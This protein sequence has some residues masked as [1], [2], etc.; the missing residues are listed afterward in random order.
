MQVLV[1][2]FPLKDFIEDV[3][4]GIDTIFLKF[5]EGGFQAFVPQ[6]GREGHEIG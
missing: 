1:V 4:D 2:F 3:L 5:V 6:R